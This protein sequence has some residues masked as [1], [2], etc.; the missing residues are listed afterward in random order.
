[1]SSVREF[2]KKLEGRQVDVLINN[3]AVADIPRQ[4]TSE[5]LELTIATN[6]LGHFLL[7]HLLMD[8]LKTT[9]GRVVTV[10]SV[11]HTWIKEVKG[12]DLEGDLQFQYDRPLATLE[13]YAASKLMNILF[14]KELHMKLH[15]TGV[16]AYCL[17]PGIVNTDIFNVMTSRV[18]Y[19]LFVKLFV[20]AYAKSSAEGAQTT[21]ML[22]ASKELQ[23]VSGKYFVDCKVAECSS[24]AKDEGLA[25]KLWEISERL[26]Q[27]QP[28]EQTL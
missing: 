25:K 10:S 11:G 6:H 1:M 28:H 24:L 15:G 22:A 5:G 12:L 16:T 14:T 13:L 18:W 4:L 9:R 17:H 2:A 3:A 7:T 26:V 27:L 20:W 23:D 8:N 21:I 19:G